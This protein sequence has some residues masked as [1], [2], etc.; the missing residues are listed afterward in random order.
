MK[1]NAIL[2][3]LIRLNIKIRIENAQLKI[4]GHPSQVTPEIVSLIRSH[5]AE[6]LS[7]LEASNSAKSLL[8]NI[9]VIPERD[10]YLLSSSQRRLWLLTQFDTENTAYNMPG[11]YAFEGAL[12]DVGLEAAFFSLIARHEILRTVFREDESGDIR[13]YIL[14][15]AQLG[16][17]LIRKDLRAAENQD[18][19]VADLIRE[20]FQHPFDLR[21]GPLLRA[22]LYQLEDQRWIFTYV[23]HHIISDGWSM[24]IL[25]KELLLFYNAQLNSVPLSIAP[26]NIQYKDYAS[27]QQSQLSEGALSGHK[28]Y[29]LEQFSGVLPILELTGDKVRPAVKTYH[30]GA[31]RV[32]LSVELSHALRLL[33]QEQGATVF[34]GLLAAVNGLLYRY[35]GQEDQVIGSPIAGREHA[36]LEGQIGF[37][38]NMLALRSRFSGK[39][40]FRE[41]LNQVKQVTLEA[42]EHQIYPFDELVEALELKRDMSRNPL[43][44]VGL[45]LQNAASVQ[46]K[47]TY[48]A[49]G[50]L[51]VKRSDQADHGIS[52]FDLT[53]GFTEVGSA[54]E[55]SLEYNIDI[56]TKETAEQLCRHFDQLLSAMLAAPDTSIDALV[57]LDV[58]EQHKLLHDFNARAGVHSEE[59]TVL[60]LFEAQVK[61]TPEA[62]ALTFENTSLT[63]LELSCI[64][65]QFAAYL[66]RIYHPVPNDL[67]GLKLPRTE[68]MVIGMLGI[69]KTGAAYLPIDPDYPQERL[70]YII[71]DSAC[72]VLVDEE[73]LKR[74]QQAIDQPD[75]A[76]FLVE[77]KPSDL[78]Y[79]IYTSGST[80]YPKGVMVS[81]GNLS[82]FLGHVKRNYAPDA[83]LSLPFVASNSFDISVF[84][85]FCSLLSGGRSV[86]LTKDQVQDPAQFVE[87]LKGVNA[88]D[89]VP[90]VY[91]GL[92]SYLTDQGLSAD[93]AH[94]SHLFIGGDSIPDAL[95][96][97]LSK[98]F[99][100]AK[101]TVTYGP[102]EGTIFCT[103]LIYNPGEINRGIKGSI[104]G[105]PIDGAKIYLTDQQGLL[106]PVGVIGEIC[107]GGKGLSQGYLNRPQLTSA[108]FVDCL[109]E[110]GQQMY[111]TGDLGRWL[112]DGE[113]EFMGRKDNQ[114]KIR[115]YR[116]ELGEIEHVLRNHEEV[117]DVVV[118]PK[119]DQD[120]NSFLAAFIE[121][122]KRVFLTPSTSEYFVYDDLLY[123]ALT[124]NDKRNFHYKEVFKQLLKDK[125]V[126][127]LGAGGDAILSQF[128]IEAG[129]KK[130]Y[131]V[132][133]LLE[134]F[135]K[136]KKVI[137][138]LGLQDKIILIHG[139][140]SNIQLPEEVDYCVSEIVGSIGGSEGASKLINETR[141]LLKTP[142]NMIPKRSLT[143]I[144]AVNFPDSLHN[145]V[146]DEIGKHYV[147]RVFDYVGYQFD[148]RMCVENFPLENVLSDDGPFEDLDFTNPIALEE[149]HEIHLKFHKRG[150]VNGFV[151]WLN[152]YVDEEHIIDTLNEKY[153]WLPIYL[154]VFY[155]NTLVE[156]DDYIKAKITRTLAANGLNPD[157]TISGTLFRQHDVPV[158]FDFKSFN[159]GT[160]FRGNPFY[161]K[162]FE[163]EE[164]QVRETISAGA[165]KLYLKN[166]LPDHMLPSVITLL[167]KMP[168]TA[169]GKID[170]KGLIELEHVPQVIDPERIKPR[171]DIEKE[172]VEVWK[173]VLGDI[174]IGPKD[175]FFALG[176]HSLR[177]TRLAGQILKKFDVKISLREL[178]VHTLL[179]EQARLIQNLGKSPYRP[180]PKLLPADGYS[181]S[182]S[183]R[184]L[185]ILSQFEGGNNAYNTPGIHVFEGE[186]DVVGLESS[187]LSLIE[188]H[189]ILRTV[190]SEH[191]EGDLL[192][193]VLATEELGF[194][195][196]CQDLRGLQDQDLKVAD[197][198]RGDFE[199]PFDL[200]KGPLLRAGLYQL[201]DNRWIFTYVMH[202]IISDGW[203]MGILIKE[204]FLFYNAY[205]NSA[206]DSLLPLNIQY[207]D[208]AAWQQEQL[209]GDTLLLHQN[210]WM[211]QFSGVLPV[212]EL[213]G[214]KTRPAVKSY[215]GGNIRAALPVELS[216]GLRSL[217]LEHGATLFMGLLTALNALLYRYT[218]QEDIIVGSPIAGREHADLEDQIGFYVNT[219]A[220][221]SRFSG[222]DSYRELLAQTRQVTLAAYEHQVYPF[223][224]LVDVLDLKRDMSRNPLFDVLIVLQNAATAAELGAA[225]SMDG[226]TVKN[227]LEIDH[228]V[229]KFDLTF[230]FSESG[231]EINLGIEYNSDVFNRN[232]VLQLSAHF[233][234][235]LEAMI[236]APDVSISQLDYLSAAEQKI[237][238]ADFN[239]TEVRYAEDKTVI[240]LFEAQVR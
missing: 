197:L 221:R 170:R 6:I 7:Y 105:K 93:F 68:W 104:I 122:K 145:Y 192:Q 151:V 224:E 233:T 19:L 14:S 174:A 164:V 210:Y 76:E 214:E 12:D 217:T 149:T 156:A 162:L 48:A 60:A 18:L 15:P 180:I 134:T 94:I 140:I 3:E 126:L 111:K 139:D 175:D 51:T 199:R 177:A 129:A 172:L 65:G 23:M 77:A 208:Y 173:F 235:L 95:L 209:R 238:L 117:N 36:D 168:L 166:K 70:D 17:H 50:Q 96:H 159:N 232:E 223:D 225:P 137:E 13:Q 30:G 194:Q 202:H 220:L 46:D 106:C 80:G 55:L 101:L 97:Q 155:D 215:R 204:L 141:R 184:R 161:K 179:E 85:L 84:Q 120:G 219:L 47:E 82:N 182:S 200:E 2:D 136:A 103:H 130:V 43:F 171:N 37:Y 167:D 131:S 69:L 116:I 41:L 183:Q 112:V 20:A 143:K 64:S 205:V 98:I 133:I 113:I 124:S 231:A 157:F 86:L 236:A 81:H 88:I 135:N 110:P 66:S 90:G 150:V 49:V 115:G 148:M 102:T 99:S 212:L 158:S 187:F 195:L 193:Y 63:Y 28:S 218:G 114:V 38:V 119:K 211:E 39:D 239:A 152:L 72:K 4:E 185:W 31:V 206:P 8:L 207:K 125:V 9:P 27:W 118:L 160:E 186:L 35:T 62:I 144:A 21:T 230:T 188:R 227:Y 44:D 229:S 146:F 25:I 87:V 16:F 165:L 121:K 34:I 213:A 196:V 138:D 228:E 178:F 154:P 59:K 54:L 222:K 123:Y 79:L 153:N 75:G 29:W 234:Q 237:I 163:K 33:A 74:F 26:L 61:K 73:E 24:G 57:Y 176:G 40:S 92:V 100:H 91:Q 45:V 56:Y 58:S 240:D 191:G 128:C 109:F 132:E 71:A 190:F 216:N 142:S 201:A 1:L 203:S 89:T 22:C 5:K 147:K 10:G 53:F 11:V 32:L 42:Y 181:L 67:I 189:E 226:L 107:I 127:D 198:V 78:A 52:K 169:H 83:P 108:Q